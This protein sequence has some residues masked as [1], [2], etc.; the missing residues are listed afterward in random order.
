MAIDFDTIQA[1]LLTYSDYEE[2][3]SVARAKLYITA[4]KRWLNLVAGSASN[5]S[6]SMTFNVQQIENELNHARAYVAANDTTKAGRRGS[7]RFLGGSRGF[8]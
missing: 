1:D 6:S 3:G 5:Q 4:A 2:T 7:V 8:R